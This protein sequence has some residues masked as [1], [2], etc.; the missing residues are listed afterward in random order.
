MPKR[1]AKMIILFKSWSIFLSNQ[2]LKIE[3][4]DKKP[5]NRGKPIKAIEQTI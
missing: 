3:S 2:T 4:F 1:I 5:E